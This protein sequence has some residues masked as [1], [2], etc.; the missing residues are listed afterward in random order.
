VLT[1]ARALLTSSPAGETAYIGADLRDTSAILA[2][3]SQTL[4]FG[5]PVALMFLMTLQYVPDADDPYA[6]VRGYLD[7]LVPGSVLVVSDT[8][9]E[10]KDPVIT[11]GTRRMNEG[12]GGRVTQ[13]RAHFRAD[14]PV[15]RGPGPGRTRPD[16]HA[17]LAPGP[18]R[19]GHRE[20]LAGPLRGGPQAVIGV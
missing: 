5:Q 1:H 6:I 13:T 12:M 10:V 15:L 17:P 9:N 3:A 16:L 4:D 7:A 20:R 8:T 14:R 2:Q 18:G 19:A 11:E